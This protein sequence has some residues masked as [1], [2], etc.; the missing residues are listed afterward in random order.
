MKIKYASTIIKTKSTF[1]ASYFKKIRM[2]SVTKHTYEHTVMLATKCIISNKY[3]YCKINI[4]Q[5]EIP[6]YNNP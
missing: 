5:H 2:W 4:C 6:R 1:I 3:Y